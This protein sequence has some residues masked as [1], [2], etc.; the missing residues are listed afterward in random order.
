MRLGALLAAGA[1]T[2]FG[3]E[4]KLL[5][6]WRGRPLV[7]WAADAL[8]QAGCDRLIAV[9]SSP[10][11]AA[12]LPAAFECCR[13]PPG[14]PMSVSV[15]AAVA[16]AARMEARCVLL[17]LGDMPEVTPD[18][19]RRLLARPGSAACRAGRRRLPPAQIADADFA[20][21]L[22]LPEGDHGARDLIADLP[23]AR[24]IPISA[25][26]ARDIDRPADLAG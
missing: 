15:K 21:V 8:H 10:A 7:T 26:A 13:V 2:R 22:A 5:A 11:V 20:R 23:E 14:L 9:T 6:P 18:L 4:D 24:L 19:L 25:N 17:C 16:A 3:P 1:S 12:A